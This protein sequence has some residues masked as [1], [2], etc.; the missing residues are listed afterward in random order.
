MK[1]AQLLK[2]G[3]AQTTKTAW[4]LTCFYDEAIDSSAR[5]KQTMQSHCELMS[6]PC[7]TR[8]SR[9]SIGPFDP[10]GKVM[11]ASASEVFLVRGTSTAAPVQSG[12]DE[13]IHIS[14]SLV[15][16]LLQQGTQVPA[17]QTAW[18]LLGLCHCT[19]CQQKLDKVIPA[20]LDSQLQRG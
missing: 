5:A 2:S 8:R 1:A 20:P 16:R 6:A 7:I 13:G 19:C 15:R 10:W 3:K 18:N 9:R 17:S 14:C 11:H 4:E 12:T